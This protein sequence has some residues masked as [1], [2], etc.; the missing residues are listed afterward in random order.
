MLTRPGKGP[1]QRML[2]LIALALTRARRGEQPVGP[3]LDEALENVESDDFFRVGAVWAARAEAAWLAGD[4]DT[5]RAEA[6]AGLDTATEHADPWLV[7][8]LRRW[9]YLTGGD[10]E[11]TDG[12]RLTPFDD[13]V[14]GHWQAAAQ[15]WTDRGCP[16]DAAIAQLGG[17]IAAV[18]SALGTFRHL[19]AR[20][21]AH[22][23]QQ[24]LALL[25]GPTR[26]TRPTD[27]SADPDGLTR[28]Q[29]QVVELLATGRSDTDIAAA[30][31]LS[32]KTVGNHVSAILAKLGVDN[33]TQA[34][35][36]AGAA[37]VA[38]RRSGPT[39]PA[40]IAIIVA[41]LAGGLAAGY[42]HSYYT[43]NRAL[44][45]LHPHSA[46]AALTKNSTVTD[47]VGDATDPTCSSTSPSPDRSTT[48]TTPPCTRW[49]ARDLTI[50]PR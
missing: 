14:R 31:H 17:D 25:R 43:T 9:V 5:A 6:R 47:P 7:G 13:E 23:A 18:Q 28:R 29:R 11:P 16:Y 8:A 34:A 19:G 22:R 24:R 32:P 2:A 30:L 27:I 50:R 20:A 42:A 4:D 46:P 45:A 15:A 44:A 10:P 21:A 38:T 36:R 12:D 39:L 1:V 49:W 3:L 41:V 48:P 26:R 33:R 37:D 40:I 35:A